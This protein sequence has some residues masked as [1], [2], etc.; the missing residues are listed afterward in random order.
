MKKKINVCENKVSFFDD[1][2]CIASK[3][4]DSCCEG[5][6][7]YIDD[8]SV[9]KYDSCDLKIGETIRNKMQKD[10][11]GYK[12]ALDNRKKCP[13]LNDDG[14]CNLIIAEDEFILC[15]ICRE[16]PRFYNFYGRY[17]EC[18]LGLCCEEVSRFL[19][20]ADKHLEIISEC[21]E[22][23]FSEI[24]E[25]EV[26]DADSLY[27]IRENLLG[28]IK[29]KKTDLKSKIIDIS[30]LA[31]KNNID[32]F[33]IESENEN[34]K[35]YDNHLELIAVFAETEAID[36]KWQEYIFEMKKF[37]KTENSILLMENLILKYNIEIDNILIY[38]VYRYFIDISF[39]YDIL[40]AVEFIKYN[41]IIMILI[42]ASN[43]CD[44]KENMIELVKYWSKQIEYDED[45]I[46]HLLK[47]ISRKLY[48]Y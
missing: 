11:Y 28:I 13:F 17:K 44:K 38:L 33:E 24:D 3:C 32:F 40:I 19:L 27:E 9:K 48:R 23:T 12:F 35:L 37:V 10:E 18:G 42:L 39:K 7:V 5:W 14:L 20:D 2:K 45:N 15:E 34:I 43:K 41:L 29:S 30:R 26:E 8:E 1:F 31:V 46:E 6:D 47:S 21:K 25:F 36:D 4:S 16:H 22:D